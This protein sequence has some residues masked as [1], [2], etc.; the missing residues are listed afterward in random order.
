MASIGEESRDSAAIEEMFR[1]PIHRAASTVLD[2]GLF[3]KTIPIAAARI[4][5]RKK[6][7]KYRTELEKARD[8]LRLER[9]QAV[10][11]DPD[12]L[13]ASKGGKC[14]LLAPDVKVNDPG[15]WSRILQAAVEE[16]ELGV[17]P[18]D[19]RLHYEYW[20]YLEIMKAI[21]PEESQDEIP[22]GFSIVGHVAHLNL[23]EQ[24]LPYK[25]LIAQVLR[26]KN[27]TVRT[28]I[29]KTDDVGT[30]SEYRTFGY[31]VLAGVD[32]MNVEIREADC[33]FRFDYSKVY[34]N[35]R[36]NTEHKRL[37]AMFNPGE[38]VADVMAGVGPFAIP[39]GKKGVFVWANDLNPDSFASLKD[40][41]TRNKVEKYVHAFCEDGHSFI[42]HAADD[43]LNLSKTNKDTITIAPKRSRTA[44]PSDPVPPPRTV[45]IPQTVAHFVMNLPATAIDFLPA[46]SG[47]YAGHESLFLPNTP[48]KLPMVHVHCFSTKSDDNVRESIDICERISGELGVTIKPDDEELSIHDY[49]AF[50]KSPRERLWSDLKY[51]AR[52]GDETSI[53]T[54]EKDKELPNVA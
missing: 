22:V 32:E 12:P 31:E 29:N 3:S 28:V 33:I 15:T 6:I 45:T 25:H 21:L 18:F 54:L 37:V 42:H 53:Q 30:H 51:Q 5:D 39:A 23:R 19:L 52:D 50:R 46:F 9:L 26:D 40:A 11:E 20:T 7:S 41:I 48:T 24:Y 16:K 8:L 14:L 47:L 49:L 44:Q 13:I 36:L 38:V 35:S 34:W 1:P 10:T 2:R 17:I 4:A 43:L 27:P